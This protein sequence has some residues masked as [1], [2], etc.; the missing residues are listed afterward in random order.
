MDEELHTMGVVDC[1]V[2]PFELDKLLD[3][4]AQYV[5]PRDQWPKVE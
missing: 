3:C 4:V 1:L 2:K 5:L